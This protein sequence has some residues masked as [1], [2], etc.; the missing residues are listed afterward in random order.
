MTE[1]PP[2]ATQVNKS[3]IGVGLKPMPSLAPEEIAQAICTCRRPRP[4]ARKLVRWAWL[5]RRSHPKSNKGF[6]KSA[7][8]GIDEGGARTGDQ[9]E[10]SPEP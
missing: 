9:S 8:D 7:L 1:G 5:W 10:G 6:S 4:F 2:G 3:G